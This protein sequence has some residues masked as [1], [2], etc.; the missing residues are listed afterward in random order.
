MTLGW[1]IT[2]ENLAGFSSCF[3]MH[4]DCKACTVIAAVEPS[5]HLDRATYLFSSIVI[6]PCEVKKKV[7]LS[8]CDIT[9]QPEV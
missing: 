1:G 2:F 6:S 8:D 7:S 4:L 3:F 5:M 9:D